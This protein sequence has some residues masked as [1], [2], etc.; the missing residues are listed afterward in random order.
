[1]YGFH[2]AY[3]YLLQQYFSHGTI[4]FGLVTLTL[5]FDLLLVNFNIGCYLVMVA[6]RTLLKTLIQPRFCYHDGIAKQNNDAILYTLTAMII[7]VNVLYVHVFTEIFIILH[8]YIYDT[9]IRN[10][11]VTI[12]RFR[13]SSLPVGRRG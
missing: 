6:V 1:M 10:L 12:T 7:P 4:L 3:W 13:V 2:A 5:K 9:G 8:L 11:R